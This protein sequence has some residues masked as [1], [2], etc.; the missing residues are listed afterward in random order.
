MI[1]QRQNSAYDRT[2]CF[3]LRSICFGVVFYWLFEEKPRLPQGRRGKNFCF[4]YLSSGWDCRHSSSALGFQ[5]AAY[6]SHLSQR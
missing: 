4:G 5:Q 2:H 6:F 1:V 3:R